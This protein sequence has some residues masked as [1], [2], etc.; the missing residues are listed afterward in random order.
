M[1]HQMFYIYIY[2]KSVCETWKVFMFDHT[3]GINNI[4]V[5]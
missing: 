2:K 5:L 4:F 3:F 1:N